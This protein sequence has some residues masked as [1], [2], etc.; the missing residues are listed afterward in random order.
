MRKEVL[1][2][3]ILGSL[4]G[5]GFGF[6]MWK[7]NKKES[8]ISQ[9]LTSILTQPFQTPQPTNSSSL[10][11]QEPVNNGLIQSSPVMVK[12]L[13]HPNAT[14]FLSSDTNDIV[15]M[16]DQEGMFSTQIEPLG[17]INSLQLTSYS[18]EVQ[19]LQT[20]FVYTA[21]K[22]SES[23]LQESSKPSADP[24]RE[25]IAKKLEGTS[26]LITATGKVTEKTETGIQLERDSGEIVQAIVAPPDTEFIR[27]RDNK[28]IKFEEL[29]LGDYV[30]VIGLQAGSGIINTK[31]VLVDTKADF[32]TRVVKK[33]VVK[34]FKRTQFTLSSDQDFIIKSSSTIKVYSLQGSTATSSKFSSIT[35]DMQIVAIGKV[36]GTT[37]TPRSI[38]I[39]E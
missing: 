10:Q 12:G 25:N 11:V 33:G 19:Q 6:G 35:N 5:I 29:G 32:A 15:V 28:E 26:T 27:V 34:D 24:I 22:F 9:S 23:Q 4:I 37:M 20:S 36:D 38:F 2:A 3:L 7:I 30:A 13:F 31:R 14:I 18:S 8:S 17:G 1:F 39:V 16:S 21:E